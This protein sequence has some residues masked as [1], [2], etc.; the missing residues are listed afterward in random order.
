[1]DL[2][3]VPGKPYYDNVLS[4]IGKDLDFVMPQYYNGITRP[5]IDG[6]DGT[7][8]GSTS[9]LS[10]YSQLVNEFFEGD[11]RRVLFGFCIDECGF[12]GSNVNA[13]Q[14]SQVM[15]DLADTYPC[16]GGAFFWVSEDDQGGSW[17]SVV[18]ST[19]QMLAESN[20]AT[21]TSSPT[22]SPVAVAPTPNTVPAPSPIQEENDS[23][24]VAY[25]GN[26]QPCPPADRVA[27]YTHIVISF[28]VTY[29]WTP[30]ENICSTTCEIYEPAVCNNEPNPQLIS[31]WQAAGKKVML[32]FGGESVCISRFRMFVAHCTKSIRC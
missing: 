29:T 16:N 26:W 9:A 2:D 4:V 7:G 24:L 23:R 14:A 25:L 31:Q 8:A 18:G 22:N 21:S 28:A 13:Q 32:S 3:L 10:H 20:C 1:M 15:T 19:I 30:T 27:Q 6:I 11:A 12:T 5:A 17:S